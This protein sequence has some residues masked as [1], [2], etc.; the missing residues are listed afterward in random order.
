MGVMTITD[1]LINAMFLLVVARQARE[2]ELDRRSVVVPLVLVF[3]VA[4]M[5]LHSIP[6]AG[7][8]LVLIG[9]L[10]AVGLILGI[11]SGFATHVRAGDRRL[12]AAR[13]GWLAAVLLVSGIGS[14]MVFAFAVSHGLRPDIA[15]FSVA[16]H[17]SASAWPAALVVMAICE[18][19]IRIAIVQLRGRKAIGD[20][21]P[22]TAAIAATA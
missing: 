10:A 2:R 17:I 7:N 4:Q 15:S 1:Y 19:T 14:R 9:L 20:H 11:A 8:D 12:A 6:T 13:V 5:Y 21:P 22:V 18:V 3:F 16:H